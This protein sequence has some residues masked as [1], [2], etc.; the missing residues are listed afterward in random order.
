MYSVVAAV[1]VAAAAAVVTAGRGRSSARHR[2]VVRRHAEGGEE[3]AKCVGLGGIGGGRDGM[4]KH[5]QV[6]REVDVV[7][8]EADVLLIFVS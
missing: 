6:R 8:D 7:G 2:H 1:A 4:P 3:L 5:A